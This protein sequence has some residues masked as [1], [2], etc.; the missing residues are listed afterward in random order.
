MG[1]SPLSSVTRDGRNF[2]CSESRSRV[3][4]KESRTAIYNLS[5]TTGITICDTQRKSQTLDYPLPVLP[6]SDSPPH[7]RI[8]APCLLPPGAES[9]LH[10]WSYSFAF[11]QFATYHDLVEKAIDTTWEGPQLL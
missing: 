7:R 6:P 2:G 8:D 4:G 1:A 9:C 3:F 11:I 5:M 10:E